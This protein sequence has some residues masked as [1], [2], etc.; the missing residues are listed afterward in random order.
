M[1]ATKFLLVVS[2]CLVALFAFQ[3][4]E[5]LGQLRATSGRAQVTF[6]CKCSTGIYENQLRFKITATKKD[7]TTYEQVFDVNKDQSKKINT[8]DLRNIV[9]ENMK[10]AGFDVSW[11]EGTAKPSTSST[12]FIKNIKK[13]DG[14]KL[15]DCEQLSFG[16]STSPDVNTTEF[17][18]KDTEKV[19]DRVRFDIE[20]LPGIF[21]G[22]FY[23]FEATT[24][25]WNDNHP[26][27]STSTFSMYI[28]DGLEAWQIIEELYAGLTAAGW[29]AHRDFE[30]NGIIFI[31][32]GN[33]QEVDHILFDLEEDIPFLTEDSIHW[34]LSFL[35]E[36]E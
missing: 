31:S 3:V 13:V 34:Q 2:L 5:A 8:E 7:G 26:F 33:G 14:K 17:F 30:T 1:N 9:A 18:P 25:Y 16:L 19:K 20:N 6:H 15:N 36:Q 35:T 29:I 32:A 21:R 22:G 10:N 11:E 4:D 24:C 28:Q 23:V 27:H 12:M